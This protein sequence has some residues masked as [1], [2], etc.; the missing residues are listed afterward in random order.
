MNFVARSALIQKKREAFFDIDFIKDLSAWI[1][2]DQRTAL[3]LLDIVL[4]VLQDP[5]RGM[6]KPEPLKHISA[7]TW[8]RRLTLEHRIVYLVRDDRIDFL[9]ARYHY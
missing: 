2:V 4:A 1:R 6:G 7:N 9:Q 8:S 5:F 3:R